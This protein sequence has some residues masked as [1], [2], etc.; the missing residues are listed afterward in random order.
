MSKRQRDIRLSLQPMKDPAGQRAKV[1]IS[2]D[3]HARRG[4]L[5]P[6]IAP[7]HNQRHPR[8]ELRAIFR[9]LHAFKELVLL[10]R[11]VALLQECNIL[12][13]PDKAHMGYA[14]DKG[15]WRS[16]SMMLREVCPKL[17]GYLECLGDLE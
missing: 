7:L 8:S 13:S 15:V 14:P 6:W 10:E 4:N 1:D 3:L 11:E 12:I 9:V 5:L 2:A 17:L 16:D